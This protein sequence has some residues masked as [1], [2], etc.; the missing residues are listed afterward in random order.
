MLPQDLSNA[1]RHHKSVC[2]ARGSSGGN[3]RPELMN[4]SPQELNDLG[5]SPMRWLPQWR[6]AGRTTPAVKNSVWLSTKSLAILPLAAVWLAEDVEWSGGR[7]TKRLDVLI[8]FT[9]GR[10]NSVP[11]IPITRRDAPDSTLENQ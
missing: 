1:I 3:A 4:P 7:F 5:L 8:Q 2:D 9:I 6:K 11:Q 10:K